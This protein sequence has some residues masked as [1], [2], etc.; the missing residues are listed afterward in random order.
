MKALK[1]VDS[2]FKVTIEA[3][4]EINKPKL[5]CYLFAYKNEDIPHFEGNDSDFFTPSTNGVHNHHLLQHHDVMKRYPVKI[6]SNA[7]F[8]GAD[9][10]VR[11]SVM[12]WGL[13][14]APLELEEIA[15]IEKA[16]RIGLSAAGKDYACN[17]CENTF[18]RYGID[19]ALTKDIM[20]E[21]G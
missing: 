10:V 3:L 6:K 13:N 17:G 7:R 18:R 21:A 1:F 2:A 20:K 4:L 14:L 9:K 8:Y 19:H 5:T 16:M 12:E 11:S 15:I